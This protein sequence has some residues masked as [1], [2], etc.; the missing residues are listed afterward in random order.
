L[1]LQNGQAQWAGGTLQGS[2]SAAFGP[3][4][5]YEL[6]LQAG[7]LNLAQVP[8]AGKVADRVTGILEEVWN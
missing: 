1:R 3:K 2:L 6:K 8:L 5:V 4:P 7:G